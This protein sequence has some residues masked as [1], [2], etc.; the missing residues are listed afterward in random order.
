[1]FVH[2]AAL[3]GFSAPIT[4][5]PSPAGAS[6]SFV[7]QIQADFAAKTALWSKL[8][9]AG[10]SLALNLAIALFILLATVWAGGWAARLTHRAVQGLARRHAVDPTLQAFAASVARN[11][12]LIVG[13]IA[14]LQQLGV[15]TTSIIAILGA[16]SLAIGLALQG[17]LANVAAGVLI[18]MLRPFRVGERVSIGG[19][20]GVVRALDL[21]N[22]ELADPDNV[23]V[24]VPN[25]KA[26]GDVIVNYSR[27]ASRRI[28]LNY[29]I[30]YADDVDVAL[31]AML[32]AAKAD[33]RVLAS[34][35]PWAKLTALADSSQTVTLRAW[36][37]PDDW[38]DAR[39]DLT[40]QVKDA[41][42]GANIHFP[43]PH[44]VSVT[45]EEMR[46]GAAQAPRAADG[47]T[48]PRRQ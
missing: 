32:A 14:V 5:A 39:F 37:K 8:V 1:V 6:P 35:A 16:A 20:E 7:A 40:K 25:G 10:G 29:G 33:K 44:Q 34:P 18:L 28:E 31:A 48:Q 27:P 2:P 46:L 26:F 21:F 30:D 41:L 38:W 17:A 45:R 4:A 19:K 42:T 15:R 24:T 43:Y 36:V 13:I 11:L 22:T 9:D 3:G 12:V 23:R 47:A